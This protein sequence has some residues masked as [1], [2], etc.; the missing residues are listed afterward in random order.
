MQ[1]LCR[2]NQSQSSWRLLKRVSSWVVVQVVVLLE[3]LYRVGGAGAVVAVHAAGVVLQ[4]LQTVL[5]PLDRLT[6]GAGA[7][8]AAGGT[9][10]GRR[11]TGRGRK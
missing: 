5:Q 3:S 6:L 4:L 10:A 2:V 8:R 7:Q 1:S 11:R 9:A